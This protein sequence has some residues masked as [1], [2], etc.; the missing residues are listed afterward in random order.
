MSGGGRSPCRESEAA[1]QVGVRL[2]ANL[3]WL[4]REPFALGRRYAFKCGTA[5]VEMRPEAIVRVVNASSLDCAQRDPGGEERGG[6]GH[7][8]GWTARR[9]STRQTAA[10]TP[11]PRFVVVDGYEIAG[12][13]IVT[14]ALAAEDYDRR[15]IRW[16]AQ[17]MTAEERAQL[18]GRRGLVV[19]LTGLSGSGK[20]TIARRRSGS[21]ASGAW[22]PTCW[23]GTSIRRGLCRDLGFSPEDR[24][25]N[26][27]R[28][29]ETANLFRDAGLVVLAT[30]I[31]PFRAGRE[32]ARR[33]AR[34]GLSGGL[35]TGQPGS[36][37]GPGPQKVI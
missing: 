15:N 21:S 17:A 9:P 16:S 23:T 33:I 19:W 35:G 2:R 1:P 32:E 12:G 13:G 8:P 34:G 4:G 5:K 10:A 27:R 11:R 3:F 6:G 36:L 31:S 25:E 29:A 28:A 18:T 24:T 7:P 37:H 20:T 14:Q 26:I 22:P 30:F